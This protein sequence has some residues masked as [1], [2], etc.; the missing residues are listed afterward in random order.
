MPASASP[1]PLKL[2]Q[3]H[4]YDDCCHRFRSSAY[5]RYQQCYPQRCAVASTTITTLPIV[6]AMT[7]PTLTLSS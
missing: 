3:D 6:T 7:M 5:Y 1:P 4:R 2:R